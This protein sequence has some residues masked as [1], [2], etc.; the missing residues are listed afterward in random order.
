M[1]RPANEGF[2]STVRYVRLVNDNLWEC[3]TIDMNNARKYV[4]KGTASTYERACEKNGMAQKG[5]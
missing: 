1:A 2:D 3:G 4:K 5:A